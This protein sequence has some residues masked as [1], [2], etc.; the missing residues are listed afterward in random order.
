MLYFAPPAQ[1][2]INTIEMSPKPTII[3]STQK[4]PDDEKPKLYVEKKPQG[5]P[6]LKDEN[7]EIG[8]DELE[9]PD[10]TDADAQAQID[11]VFETYKALALKQ[12]AA[13]DEKML[14]RESAKEPEKAEKSTPSGFAGILQQYE[15][16]KD[17]AATTR[18][19]K[20]TNPAHFSGKSNNNTND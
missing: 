9:R 1:A 2:Q 4:P 13:S 17:S 18:T 11:R 15:K 3:Q 14:K 16:K 7:E 6:D 20:I 10:T 8:N 12:Q 19:L 5:L